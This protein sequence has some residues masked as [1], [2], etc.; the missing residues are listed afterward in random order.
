MRGSRFCLRGL[1]PIVTKRGGKRLSYYY[2]EQGYAIVPDESLSP[3]H[4]GGE[5]YHVG[6]EC[7]VCKIPLLLL[8]DLDCAPFRVSEKKKLFSELDRLPLYYCWRCCAE[9]LSYKINGRSITIFK[10]DGKKEGDDFPYA[11][12]PDKFPKRPVKLVPVPYETAKLLAVAQEIDEYWLSE[13]D[14][15]SLQDRLRDLR[16]LKFAKSGLCR[17]Q[18]GGLLYLIQGHDYIKCPNPEC[19]YYVLKTKFSGVR[20]LELATLHNDP[21]SGL[22]M[23]ERLEEIS[24]PGDWN[25]YIQVV[26]WVCEECLTLTVSNRCD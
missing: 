11:D 15:K 16:H 9:K 22:P 3:H 1:G 8:A 26:Y 24:E 12:F 10:N 25:E 14:R 18:I 2:T 19:K 5:P 20:M 21:Y 7:P 6:A 23:C 4:F 13:D 17:H